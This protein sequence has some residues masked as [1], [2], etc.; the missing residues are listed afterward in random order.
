MIGRFKIFWKQENYFCIHLKIFKFEPFSRY[1]WT[2]P[3]LGILPAST[4]NWFLSTILLSLISRLNL[5]LVVMIH[6]L[7]NSSNHVFPYSQFSGNIRRCLCS[8]RFM[9]LKFSLWHFLQV[10]LKRIRCLQVFILFNSE[11][12]CLFQ[13]LTSIYSDFIPLMKVFRPRWP[14]HKKLR[15]TLPRKPNAKT[16]HIPPKPHVW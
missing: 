16:L 7:K 9:V 14:N 5:V 12:C 6:Q 15:S 2:Y 13:D 10:L 4:A 8:L 1:F 11:I 3:H